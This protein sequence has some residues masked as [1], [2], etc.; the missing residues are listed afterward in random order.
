MGCSVIEEEKRFN[1]STQ[2]NLSSDSIV[3]EIETVPQLRR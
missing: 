2:Y 1:H 3:K